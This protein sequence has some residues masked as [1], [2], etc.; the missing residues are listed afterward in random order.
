MWMH[1]WYVWSILCMHRLT[2][3]HSCWLPNECTRMHNVCVAR[4]KTYVTYVHSH[5][6]LIKS[7]VD[8]SL[9]ALTLSIGLTMFY[10]I[11]YDSWALKTKGEC[12]FPFSNV[13]VFKR[14]NTRECIMYVSHGMHHTYHTWILIRVCFNQAWTVNKLKVGLD[15]HVWLDWLCSMLW[16][17]FVINK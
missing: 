5:T 6:R 3:S 11:T 9:I 2:Y 16:A 13:F 4:N 15:W 17:K 14:L 1:V 8:G 12:I 10:V 7:N